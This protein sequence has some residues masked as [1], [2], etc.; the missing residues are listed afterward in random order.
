MLESRFKEIFQGAKYKMSVEDDGFVH[1]LVITNPTTNDMGKYTCDVENIV[2]SAYLDV[3]G[4]SA[5]KID[6]FTSAQ[7]DRCA[8]VR[9]N[10]LG[11]ARNEVSHVQIFL[12]VLS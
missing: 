9:K 1:K 3:D 5:L 10:A 12:P 4:E 6:I 2:T 8:F 11:S 7:R